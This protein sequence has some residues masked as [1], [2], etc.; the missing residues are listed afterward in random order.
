M[1]EFFM[2]RD[3]VKLADKLDSAGLLKEADVLDG[4]LRKLA[5]VSGDDYI[6]FLSKVCKAF[7]AGH[8]KLRARTG[9]QDGMLSIVIGGQSKP[10]YAVVESKTD[11]GEFKSSAN[12]MSEV[13]SILSSMKGTSGELASLDIVSSQTMRLEDVDQDD[14]KPYSVPEGYSVW[15]LKSNI[16]NSFLHRAGKALGL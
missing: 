2:I 9:M 5:E 4:I 10:N 11:V 6:D 15:V 8:P 13:K 3:L 12:L 7:N 14:E 1:K 16:D